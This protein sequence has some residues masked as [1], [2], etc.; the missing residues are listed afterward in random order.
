MK[1]DRDKPISDHTDITW[2]QLEE[3]VAAMKASGRIPRWAPKDRP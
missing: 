2:R 3:M 1:R